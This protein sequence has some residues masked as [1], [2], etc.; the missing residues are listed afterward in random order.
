[1]VD[2]L[3]VERA[4][5]KQRE[6]LKAQEAEEAENPKHELKEGVDK[7]T[8]RLSINNGAVDNPPA[9]YHFPEVERTPN[10]IHPY[11]H[12]PDSGRLFIDLTR[13][14]DD[15]PRNVGLQLPYHSFDF[16]NMQGH[17]LYIQPKHG[18][19]VTLPP[20]VD[21]TGEK[22]PQIVDLSKLQG[23]HSTGYFYLENM[24]KDTV[25]ILPP[26]KTE[27]NLHVRQNKDKK[28]EIYIDDTPRAVNE[29]LPKSFK[30]TVKTSKQ[31]M[32]DGSLIT[33]DPVRPELRMSEVSVA[34]ETQVASHQ[35]RPADVSEE[36]ARAA[37]ALGAQAAS[38]GPI[39]NPENTQTSTN[40]VVRV[41]QSKGD[42]GR[43]S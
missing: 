43:F 13:V 20:Q 2:K 36:V 1:M 32:E 27:A 19:I 41:G 15:R 26:G 28:W 31:A 40:P 35:T 29:P 3:D 38:V 14:P 11:Q 33:I 21:K 34:P 24:T 4:K 23:G 18:C 12:S 30:A 16:T 7:K 42:S 5:A 25:I 17:Q 39:A 9:G 10:K 22:V 6:R 37:V 8:F